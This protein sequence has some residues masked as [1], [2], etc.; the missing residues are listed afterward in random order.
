MKSIKD[1]IQNQLALISNSSLVKNMSF[2]ERVMVSTAVVALILLILYTMVFMPFI[3]RIKRYNNQI[4]I[5]K[6][7]LAEIHELKQEYLALNQKM[8]EFEEK[9]SSVEGFAI[10]PFI[11]NAAKEIG[12]QVESI[13]NTASGSSDSA[14]KE[15]NLEIKFEMIDYLQLLKLLEAIE[16][17]PRYINVK[18]VAIKTRFDN[19][20]FLNVTM[21]VSI[22]ELA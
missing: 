3:S 10:A 15:T 9:M 22:F 20:N 7:R 21:V 11:E 5:H 17:A 12:V 4:A 14:Y 6:E 16:N 1:A 2:R 18:R 13:K 8:G 19:S